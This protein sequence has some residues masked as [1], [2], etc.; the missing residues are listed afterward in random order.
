MQQEINEKQPKLEEMRVNTEHLMTEL[1]IKA[2]QEVEPKK[3][4]IAQ[5]EEIAN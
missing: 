4:Q 1:Q 2:E 5:E 3:I